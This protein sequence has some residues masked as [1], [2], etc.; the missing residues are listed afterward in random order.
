MY[1]NAHGTLN[2]PQEVKPPEEFVCPTDRGHHWFIINL[3]FVAFFSTQVCKL[4]YIYGTLSSFGGLTKTLHH[5]IW[6]W[7]PMRRLKREVRGL[8]IHILS[9]QTCT[10]V[11]ACLKLV[12]VQETQTA[13]SSR[14]AHQE[15]KL[16]R[17]HNHTNS[18]IHSL[19]HIMVTIRASSKREMR[20]RGQW[21]GRNTAIC[22]GSVTIAT[23]HFLSLMNFCLDGRNKDNQM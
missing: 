17:L 1:I 19:A 15:E 3:K 11:C 20:K 2:Q 12:H 23:P 21:T 18:L 10:H 5:F 9:T 14:E 22:Q 16:W 13:A 6:I 8:I 7:E 4:I